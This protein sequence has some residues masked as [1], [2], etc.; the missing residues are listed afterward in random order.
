MKPKRECGSTAKLA[1]LSYSLK[2]YCLIQLSKLY[3]HDSKKCWN[4]W[5]PARPRPA[6]ARK[7]N[8]TPA[9]PKREREQ[10]TILKQCQV[11]M[12]AFLLKQLC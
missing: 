6:R 1:L 11:G 12:N 2:L 4:A 5:D 7:E 9:R 3:A 10:Y 8:G